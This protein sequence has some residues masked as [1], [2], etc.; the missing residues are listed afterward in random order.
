[1]KRKDSI[2]KVE[3]PINFV[4]IVLKNFNKAGSG[5]AGY[6]KIKRDQNAFNKILAASGPNELITSVIL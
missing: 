2:V 1:M 4:N 5:S 3:N 6:E